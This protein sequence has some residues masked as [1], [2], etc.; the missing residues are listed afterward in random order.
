MKI[1]EKHEKLLYWYIFF[2]V[3]PRVVILL[4][5]SFFIFP[6]LL[7]S[8]KEKYKYY[9][10]YIG[11]LQFAAF[12]FGLSAMICTLDLLLRPDVDSTMF[13]TSL[14][15]IPNY[16]YWC[17]IILFLVS[18]REHLD[19]S[20]I[21]MAIFHGITVLVIYHLILQ[22]FLGINK[23]PIFKTSNPNAFAFLLICFN[24]IGT[25]YT[26]KKKGL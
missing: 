25:Y 3:F 8:F 5:L 9:F 11:I 13:M 15:V 19:F 22:P 21:T 14:R 4:N 26:Y 24:V 10:K 2:T 6:F 23:L 18:H 7:L 17:I 16:I 12:F 20:L 1:I